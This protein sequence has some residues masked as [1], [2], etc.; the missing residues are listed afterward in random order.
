MV[1]S[2]DV[3]KLECVFYVNINLDDIVKHSINFYVVLK[4]VSEYKNGYS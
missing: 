2:F 4:I 3:L 1:N